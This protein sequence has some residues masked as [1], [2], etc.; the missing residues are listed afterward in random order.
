LCGCSF[1]LLVPREL[2]ILTPQWEEHRHEYSSEASFKLSANVIQ[3]KHDGLA[4]SFNS[5]PY[6]VLL[7]VTTNTGYF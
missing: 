2:R 5:S 4:F 3:L 1:E 7:H 6:T